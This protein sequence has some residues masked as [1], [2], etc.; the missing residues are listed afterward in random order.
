MIEDGRRLNQMFDMRE[1]I[2]LIYSIMKSTNYI[3]D[4]VLKK[5]CKQTALC[6]IQILYF[7]CLFFNTQFY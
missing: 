2:Q 6:F 3:F 1:L 4:L 5:I 7:I